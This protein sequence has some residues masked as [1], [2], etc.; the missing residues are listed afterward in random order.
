MVNSLRARKI[1]TCAQHLNQKTDTDNVLRMH[2]IGS[3]SCKTKEHVFTQRKIVDLQGGIPAAIFVY[4][5]VSLTTL[6]AWKT[7]IAAIPWNTSRCH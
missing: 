4:T 3:Q 5:D 7:F 2:W 6:M 1:N